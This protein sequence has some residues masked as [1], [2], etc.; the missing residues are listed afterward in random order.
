MSQSSQSNCTS[1]TAAHAAAPLAFV[2]AALALLTTTPSASA[3]AVRCEGAR[4]AP[5]PLRIVGVLGVPE[6]FKGSLRLRARATGA[7]PYL[8]LE[9]AMVAASP[10]P[11]RIGS[12]R[13]DIAN[14]TEPIPR[15]QTRDVRV[16]IDKPRFAGEY[17]GTIRSA[18]GA[19]RIP[20]TVVARGPAEIRLVGETKAIELQVVNCSHGSC[21]PADFSERLVPSSARED[22][23]APL[24]NNG[25][26]TSAGVQ[27]MQIAMDGKPTARTVPDG[28][29]TPSDPTFG[30]RALYASRL[31]PIQVERD[32]LSPGHYSGAIFL[33]VAGAEKRTE[34]PLEIDVKSGPTWAILVLLAALFVQFLVWLAARNKPRGEELRD[35]KALTKQARAKLRADD[36]ALLE[37]RLGDARDLARDG[38]LD[39][40]KKH[41]KAIERD[42]AR[43]V[44]AR[45][46]VEKAE[47]AHNGELPADVAQPFDRFRR[48][49]K[50][51]DEQA[52]LRARAE[53]ERATG[54]ATRVPGRHRAAMPLDSAGILYSYSDAGE[55]HL[56]LQ[57]RPSVPARAVALQR[58]ITVAVDHAWRWLCDA[59]VWLLRSV[60]HA[61]VWLSVYPLPWLLR[62]LLVFAFVLAG[63]KELYLNDATFGTD[64]ILAYG[65]LFVWGLTAT[66]INAALGKVIP[67]AGKD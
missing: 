40:A 63:L 4:I 42:L 56:P 20:L 36:R 13:V 62:I 64:P 33:T 17:E 67:G 37:G 44:E 41:R 49:I 31:T 3:A 34:L 26:Q 65:A 39:S 19:C 55:R 12:A 5:S 60:R 7:Q 43:L 9:S 11:H 30:L 1:R 14:R 53:L 10:T 23:F 15:G 51:G 29:L 54:T 66:A 21:W 32:A 61:V 25:S 45:R 59:A 22:T 35:L 2:V 16:S 57:G 50:S 27:G 47:A 28:V 58:S 18:D 24:V 52:V 6:T 8:E 46:W 48:A 38:R